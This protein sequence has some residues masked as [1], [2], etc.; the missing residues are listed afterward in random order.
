MELQNILFD[1]Y[2]ITLEQVMEQFDDAGKEMYE[3]IVDE[4]LEDAADCIKPSAFY[5]QIPVRILSKEAVQLEDTQFD[6]EYLAARL[7]SV[8]TAYAFEATIGEELWNARKTASDPLEE[9]LF[10]AIMKTCL[11]FVFEKTAASIAAQL[12]DKMGLYMD[13]PGSLAG[14]DLADQHKFLNLLENN[15]PN[16]EHLTV[17]NDSNLF[18]TAYSL[19]G[20]IYAKGN[21]TANCTLCPKEECSHRKNEFDGKALVTRLHESSEGK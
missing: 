20:I 15:A 18:E 1:D 9:L 21:E 10:D 17:S 16:Q 14:W 5:K 11:D 3:D 12:P 7:D 8:D 2:T 6:S 13:N 4:L 19:S